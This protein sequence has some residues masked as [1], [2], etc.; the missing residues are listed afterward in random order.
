MKHLK[1]FELFE[2]NTDEMTLVEIES[3]I[4]IEPRHRVILDMMPDYSNI[5][6]S[7]VNKVGGLGYVGN[8]KE[9]EIKRGKAISTT[10]L[11]DG[12]PTSEIFTH[13]LLHYFT[14]PVLVKYTETPQDYKGSAVETY[15]KGLD[16][17]L[18]LAKSKG[19]SPI[20]GVSIHNNLN[21]FAVNITNEES[22]NQ[23]KRIKASTTDGKTTTIYDLLMKITFDFLKSLK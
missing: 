5:K 12:L 18:L 23:L 17:L 9:R 21:E 8:F 4:E 14:I 11:F 1:N 19:Y 13:E 22:S 6:A 16:N 10:I 15:V 3:Q 2:R 7:I 20:N